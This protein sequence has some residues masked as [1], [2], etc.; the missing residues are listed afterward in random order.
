[1]LHGL[2]KAKCLILTREEIQSPTNEETCHIT[3]RQRALEELKRVKTCL[4]IL[5]DSL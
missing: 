1:M 2:F 4:E 5:V 3:N